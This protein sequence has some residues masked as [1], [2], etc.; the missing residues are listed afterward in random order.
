MLL[1]YVFA[2]AT[3]T[4]S[5]ITKG[6][7]DYGPIQ[8]RGDVALK[9][10]VEEA[11]F[12][13]STSFTG[14][15]YIT[16]STSFASVGT[17][18]QRGLTFVTGNNAGPVV[19]TE[20]EQAGKYFNV[21]DNDAFFW[22][23][24]SN[25]PAD[26]PQRVNLS[27]PTLPKE[28]PDDEQK[29]GQMSALSS[30]AS[31]QTEPVSPQDI[32]AD[33]M[34]PVDQPGRLAVNIPANE[35]V[36][37]DVVD[38]VNNT[39][40]VSAL[41]AETEN[42]GSVK[43]LSNHN[44]TEGKPPANSAQ[45]TQLHITTSLYED[46][47]SLTVY[48][49][50]DGASEMTITSV[51]LCLWTVF[52]FGALIAVVFIIAITFFIA[53]VLYL[54]SVFSR[55]VFILIPAPTPAPVQL[56]APAAYQD[57]QDDPRPVYVLEEPKSIMDNILPLTG[58]ASGSQSTVAL[59]Q[60]GTPMAL[61]IVE[62]IVEEHDSPSDSVTADFT[63]AAYV[64][65]PGVL[66]DN[67]VPDAI[68]EHEDQVTFGAEGGEGNGTEGPQII[69]A[70]QDP[71]PS[72]SASESSTASVQVGKYTMDVISTPRAGQDFG[73][74]VAA[75]ETP[76]FAP[77]LNYSESD[78]TST[79]VQVFSRTPSAIVKDG[80]AVFVLERISQTP[81]FPGNDNDAEA[82]QYDAPSSSAPS[83]KCGTAQDAAVG[84]ISK[85][86]HMLRVV[87][88]NPVTSS[89]RSSSDSSEE[90]FPARREEV[91]RAYPVAYGE[92]SASL[93]APELSTSGQSRE[94]VSNTF[95]MSQQTRSD[96]GQG[97]GQGQGAHV[98][99]V[100]NADELEASSSV[101]V[102]DNANADTSRPRFQNRIFYPGWENDTHASSSLEEG[103]C[104]TLDLSLASGGTYGNSCTSTEDEDVTGAGTGTGF[105]S[106]SRTFGLE[107]HFREDLEQRVAHE[108]SDS[109]GFSGSEAGAQ[110]R[111]EDGHVVEA[112]S[113]GRP[114]RRR[115]WR[116]ETDGV[117]Q[118]DDVIES[119]SYSSFARG[120]NVLVG[121]D[122]DTGIPRAIAARVRDASS[123]PGTSVS[124]AA[125][126]QIREVREMRRRMMERI[127]LGVSLSSHRSVDEE[128]GVQGQ[129]QGTSSWAESVWQASVEEQSQPS[130][131][132]IAQPPA[133]APVPAPMDANLS[134]ADISD[135]ASSIVCGDNIL[136]HSAFFR[137]GHEGRS[138]T[139][140]PIA[141][142]IV[143]EVYGITPLKYS[144]FIKPEAALAPAQ[145]EEAP[146]PTV[147]MA[148][149]RVPFGVRTNRQEIPQ[150]QSQVQV[151][152]SL[153][154][155][156]SAAKKG[157]D[158]N[159]NAVPRP[160]TKQA[161]PKARAPKSDKVP[162]IQIQVQA[163]VQA[164]VQAQTPGP[165]Q[166]AKS[167][168]SEAKS[169]PEIE[170][171]SKFKP[172]DWSP[173]R[174]TCIKEFKILSYV[175]KPRPA[176]APA[177]GEYVPF[178]PR[179]FKPTQW[180][181]RHPRRTAG[182]GQSER[183]LERGSASAK[184]APS[185]DSGAAVTVEETDMGT[186]GGE[187]SG[188]A[189]S[190]STSTTRGL[191]PRA[192]AL[193]DHYKQK[194]AERLQREKEEAERAEKE[195]EEREK[196]VAE[197]DTEK[198]GRRRRTRAEKGKGREVEVARL[199]HFTGRQESSRLRVARGILLGSRQRMAEQTD[200]DWHMDRVE[201]RGVFDAHGLGIH[202][203][204]P[205]SEVATTPE[206]RPSELKSVGFAATTA[207]ED[208]PTPK[209]EFRSTFKRSSTPY[210][211]TTSVASRLRDIPPRPEARL[212]FY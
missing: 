68:D 106:F 147:T 97:Q 65:A 21:E 150:P 103:Y 38:Y 204:T 50:Q 169:E 190:T 15:D 84:P 143:R 208:A 133:P 52:M 51:N 153:K 174:R 170:S 104:Y 178:S 118:E 187:G 5:V 131:Q 137:D 29:L 116:W 191:S 186:G 33:D 199:S 9:W 58:V 162:K 130:A 167:L 67:G 26:W 146:S 91:I 90:S 27:V 89:T 17:A 83:S 134:P 205:A 53:V 196:E 173:R 154:V 212:G 158:E 22:N 37:V 105:H 69:Y 136:D 81:A 41:P 39:D 20:E 123:A 140:D 11:T 119:G 30:S 101:Q 179:H 77:A 144:P 176:S 193:V 80:K 96:E 114:D 82:T 171:Y 152:A 175:P 180:S 109:R 165:S 87:N 19:A 35:S 63:D 198:T 159:E 197:K 132:V 200:E 14:F 18:L 95:G 32:P 141:A 3:L 94:P 138:G 42:T 177:R 189:S 46:K 56:P 211:K 79:S 120:R 4:W 44:V 86:T 7:T 28:K 110:S 155:A 142:T 74:V 203:N 64:S 25:V 72:F 43:V 102:Q 98:L 183:V 88:A 2:A 209:A 62:D 126:E 47:I 185:G 201:A 135:A 145:T 48:V 8:R 168:P 71:T 99:Q 181:P 115:E 85:P 45:G 78:A 23:K 113:E 117:E 108:E 125:E 157:M 59:G 31:N 124:A 6:F 121:L 60:Y 100:R 164:E 194:R 161:G 188:G 166:I 57:I 202:D 210:P 127:D 75:L 66:Q 151:V 40:P 156:K 49:T 24:D 148:D 129:E 70:E 76:N 1:A 111:Y 192:A 12:V 54:H 112:E 206:D 55:P 149:R 172:A 139:P 122:L 182:Q 93:D 13:V 128:D 195:E 10:V 184:A 16:S 92:D 160:S 207:S 61:D 34:G 163:P 107:D 73:E 36:L